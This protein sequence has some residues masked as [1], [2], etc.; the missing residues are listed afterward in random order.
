MVFL[1]V[2]LFAAYA[3]LILAIRGL[4]AKG[5]AAL[6]AQAHFLC[7]LTGA[8]G[9]LLGFELVP[10]PRKGIAGD[11]YNWSPV[12]FFGFGLL[13][14]LLFGGR[15]ILLTRERS[16]RNGPGVRFGMAIWAVAAGLY[17]CGTV[18]DHWMFFR[19]P[20][21]AG[22]VAP[23]F[24][25]PNVKCETA[26]LVRLDGNTVVY[27]CPNLVVFGRDYSKPFVP[28]PSFTQGEA[29]GKQLKRGAAS[30]TA[31]AAASKNGVVV[32][33]PASQIRVIPAQ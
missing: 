26:V 7:C 29:D 19:H 8:L 3:N 23:S 22:V 11:A 6:I 4:V 33:M 18:A 1:A 31:A 10:D 15:L 24:V 2:F 21:Q 13:T 14:V 17:I 30:A 16:V 5:C 25:G 20:D 27:R 28:W 12:P 9:L 32:A